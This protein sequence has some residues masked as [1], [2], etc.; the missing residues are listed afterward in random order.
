MVLI[1]TGGLFVLVVLTALLARVV[2]QRRVAKR[3]RIE[4][5][6]GIASLE[7]IRL[8]GL[9][10][11]IQIRGHDRTKPILLFLHGGPG[12]PQMPFAHLNAELEQ[13]F[14]VVQWDRRGA[15][16]S[17]S[18]AVPDDSMRVAQFVSDA[19]ELVQILLA[20]F[21]A[22]KCYLVAHSWGSLFGAQL[23]AQ[24]PDLFF[25]YVGIGQ[26]VDLSQTEQVLYQFALDSARK[27]R[28]E[29]AVTD[30]ER[31]GRP[32]HSNADHKFMEK[33]VNYYAEREHPSLSRIRMTRLALESPPYSW[34][35]LFK[36]P[37][38]VR[39]SF[40][41]LWKEIYYET[42]LFRQAPRID[43][44]VYFFLGRHDKVVT[45]EVAQRYFDALDAPRGKQIVWFEQSGH[46]P[47]SRSLRNIARR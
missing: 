1:T 23:V 13:H 46:W 26:T 34:I 41:R 20:R 33:W 7:R 22:P 21:G 4:S 25:A 2:A 24:Y 32:P 31:I 35:D 17:Y 42:S 15:G 27:D 28:N 45:S 14:V 40:G 16:K 43:V 12:F 6:S 39:Y 9:D 5:A 30:L 36:I 3:I 38:G 47:H 11:W 10:Q 37:L 19:H 44:P 18:R 8:G 29:K